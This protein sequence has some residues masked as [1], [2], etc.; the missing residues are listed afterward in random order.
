MYYD[1]VSTYTP[2]KAKV[3]L[4]HGNGQSAH[5]FQAKMRFLH[6]PIARAINKAPSITH[7]DVYSGGVDFVYLDAPIPASQIDRGQE[8]RNGK[9]ANPDRLIDSWVWG[10]GDPENGEIIGAE[11]VLPHLTRVLEGQG[12]FMGVIGFSEGATWATVL[13]GLLERE[14]KASTGFHTNH[15]P[16]QFCIAFSGFRF[17]HESYQWMYTPKIET[18]VLHFMGTLDT[19]VTEQ[20]T[21]RLIEACQNPTVQYFEGTH[22]IPRTPEINKR[23]TDHI[24]QALVWSLG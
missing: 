8:P 5:T 21:L 3:L 10:D 16:L 2:R 11:T 24:Q 15:P 13:S 1:T 22:Y 23:I 20:Q 7:R 17:E 14:A 19:Q 6:E 12:P 18:P 9:E 4:L